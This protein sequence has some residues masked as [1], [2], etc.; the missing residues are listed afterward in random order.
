MSKLAPT[1]HTLKEQIEAT[2]VLERAL[3]RKRQ[4]EELQADQAD[5]DLALSDDL[6]LGVD[7]SWSGN[8]ARLI[9]PIEGAE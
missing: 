3:L 1:P 4:S 6:P 7:N 2:H 5:T 9:L 8:H